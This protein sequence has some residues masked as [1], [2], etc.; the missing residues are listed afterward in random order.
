MHIF[1]RSN[2]SQLVIVLAM[3]GSLSSGSTLAGTTSQ[4]A[5]SQM[6]N[7]GLAQFLANPENYQIYLGPG[8]GEEYRLTG[9]RFNVSNVR[10]AGSTLHVGYADYADGKLVGKV[11]VDGSYSGTFTTTRSAGTFAMKFNDDGTAT[12]RWTL[13]QASMDRF[14]LSKGNGDTGPNEL[15]FRK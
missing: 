14:G 12:G 9:F 11:S 13:D 10:K 8:I 4:M 5:Q 2:I 15:V 1:H 6:N 7:A 3:A